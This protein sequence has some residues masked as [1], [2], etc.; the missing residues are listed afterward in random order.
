MSGH[1]RF[2]YSPIIDRPLRK[3]PRDARVGVWIT[4]NVEHFHWGKPAMSMT[5]MTAGL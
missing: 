1:N 4:P 3:M 2:D 5:P